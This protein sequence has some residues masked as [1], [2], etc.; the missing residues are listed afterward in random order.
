[1]DTVIEM[2]MKAFEHIKKHGD[3]IGLIYMI[4]HFDWKNYHCF[5]CSYYGHMTLYQLLKTSGTLDI[6]E[7]AKI[8]HLLILTLVYLKGN[9]NDTL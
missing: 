2:E 9:T 7:V 8:G 3:V 6:H 1:M 4:T 5:V